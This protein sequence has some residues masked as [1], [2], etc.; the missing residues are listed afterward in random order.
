MVLWLSLLTW[1]L[2]AAG[3]PAGSTSASKLY[4]LACPRLALLALSGCLCWIPA[5]SLSAA[6]TCCGIDGATGPGPLV[7]PSSSQL[8][9][10]ASV[11]QVVGGI[12][13]PARPRPPSHGATFTSVVA[14]EVLSLLG[15]SSTPGVLMTYG[16]STLPLTPCPP[17]PPGVFR[18]SRGLTTP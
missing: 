6:M 15:N 5:L 14:P 11:S 10:I 4:S 12:S 18:H 16:D 8:V 7:I 2:V 13:F 9:L 3:S 1:V 17:P